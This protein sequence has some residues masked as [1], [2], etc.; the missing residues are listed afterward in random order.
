MK[1]CSSKEVPEREL[2]SSLKTP[3]QMAMG[4]DGSLGGKEQLKVLVKNMSKTDVA[5]WCYK[6][7]WE[8]WIG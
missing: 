7:D 8:G 5:P 3:S 6:W 4:L 2:T 1:P